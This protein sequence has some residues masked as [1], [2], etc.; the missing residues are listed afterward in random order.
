MNRQEG[1]RDSIRGSAH[2]ATTA[3]GRRLAFIALGCS[4][5][6]HP[7]AA[8]ANQIC[9]VWDPNDSYAN[10]RRSPNGQVIGRRT[11]G[12]QVE[13]VDTAY[14]SLGR[15]WVNILSRGSDGAFILKSLVRKCIPGYFTPDG[16]IVP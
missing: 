13:V 7:P 5:G 11:N 3:V 8:L 1:V 2:R 6:W 9:V 16:R 4:L 14:D 10:V 15:P 12:T